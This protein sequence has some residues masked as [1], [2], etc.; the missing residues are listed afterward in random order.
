MRLSFLPNYRTFQLPLLMTSMSRLKIQQK[1]VLEMLLQALL[2]KKALMSPFLGCAAMLLM[3]PHHPVIYIFFSLISSFYCKCNS[4][5]ALLVVV[6]CC[7]CCLHYCCCCRCAIAATC[8]YCLCP[9]C[10][11]CRRHQHDLTY[12]ALM[13]S[14]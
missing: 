6:I 2:T 10:H 14:A 7:Y 3:Q 11:C 8:F 9:C 1:S 13:C 4:F 5:V 12:G